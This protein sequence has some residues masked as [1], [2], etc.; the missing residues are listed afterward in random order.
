M[1]NER[2]IKM[3]NVTNKVTGVCLGTYEARDEWDALD[4]CARDAGYADYDACCE[5]VGHDELVAI[6]I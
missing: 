5:A 1:T 3:F 6:E 4:D 2:E